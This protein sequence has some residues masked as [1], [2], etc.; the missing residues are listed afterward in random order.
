MAIVPALHGFT[1][2]GALFVV[3]KRLDD[4]QG[5]R[6]L[7]YPYRPAETKEKTEKRR[8]GEKKHRTQNTIKIITWYVTTILTE[9]M[10]YK[11]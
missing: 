3:I 1:N 7:R 6:P 2:E 9:I 11:S 10:S 8:G 4:W 5:I